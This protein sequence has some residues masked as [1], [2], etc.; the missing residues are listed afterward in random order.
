M[1]GFAPVLLLDEVV[2]HLD[3]TRRSA[4]YGE[5]EGLGAQAWL[6]GADAALFADIAAR[7]Q[8]FEVAPGQVQ[9]RA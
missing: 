7:S 5:L 6:T 1:S 9:R 2:A 4:L 3:P 8:M